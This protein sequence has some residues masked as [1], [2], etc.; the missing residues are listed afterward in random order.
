[1]NII[2]V[3]ESPQV[4]SLGEAIAWIFEFADVGT[5]DPSAAGVTL[6]YNSSGA[7]VSSSL[8]SGSASLTGSQVTAKKFTP[9][10]AGS[11]VLLQPATIDGNTVHGACKFEVMD[12]KYG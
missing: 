9:L 2:F 5:A 3:E 1:M 7:D 11:Y 12:V 8:L 10:T 6:C 4:M